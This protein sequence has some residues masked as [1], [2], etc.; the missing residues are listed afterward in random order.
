M[1]RSPWLSVWSHDPS[2]RLIPTESRV[3]DEHQELVEPFIGIVTFGRANHLIIN[4]SCIIINP[5]N[6]AFVAFIAIMIVPLYNVKVLFIR[7]CWLVGQK[8]EGAPT[9]FV[10]FAHP[11]CSTT[12]GTFKFNPMRC[13]ECKQ[14]TL[15]QESS[16]I[17]H[18]P[19]TDFREVVQQLM[20]WLKRTARWIAIC[21]QRSWVEQKE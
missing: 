21:E 9:H 14:T 7:P 11:S 15:C 8:E 2:E 19:A 18:S 12:I 16:P 5:I 10:Q 13:K 6:T 17:H 4:G 3:A 1:S 20:G